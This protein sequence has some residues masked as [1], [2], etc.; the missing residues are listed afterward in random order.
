VAAEYGG[1][2]G[3]GLFIGIGFPLLTNTIVAGNFNG[4]DGFSRDD[5]SGALFAGSTYNLIGDGTG[6]TGVRDGSGGNQVGSASSPI[7]ALLGPL[8]DNGGPTPT[9]ALLA[10][11]PARRAGGTAFAADADQRGLP[12]VVDARTDV[13]AYQAQEGE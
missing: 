11:S 4:A 1:G 7:E 5:V 9:C 8:Q 12:R 10:G 6:L 13:G 2:Q 3:G